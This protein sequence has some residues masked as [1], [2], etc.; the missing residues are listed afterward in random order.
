MYCRKNADTYE[1][2]TDA[3]GSKA[4]RLLGPGAELENPRVPASGSLIT[5]SRTGAS[6]FD[7]GRFVRSE[8]STIIVPALADGHTF[9]IEAA[10]D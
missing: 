8:N 1:E 10:I 7:G 9:E 2:A 3:F 4:F 5:T 6:N